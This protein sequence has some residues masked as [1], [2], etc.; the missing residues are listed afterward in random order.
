MKSQDN[1]RKNLEVTTK[2]LLTAEEFYNIL[3][4]KKREP[5]I[6]KPANI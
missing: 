4:P 6:E 1:V 2:P 5:F 3:T